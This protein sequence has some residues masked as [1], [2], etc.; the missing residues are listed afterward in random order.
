MDLL[1]VKIT[2]LRELSSLQPYQVLEVCEALLLRIE[3]QEASQRA[4]MEAQIRL[5]TR[6]GKLEASKLYREPRG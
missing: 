3:A 5:D 1:S 6:L 4:T 2:S